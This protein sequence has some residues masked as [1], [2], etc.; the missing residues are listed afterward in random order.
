[1]K[2][3][4]KR[5][6]KSYME[7]L[8]GPV[9]ISAILLIL[10]L[11]FFLNNMA[12]LSTDLAAP[13][14]VTSAVAFTFAIPLLAMRSF[15][16]ETRNKTDQLYMT[17]PITIG[18]VVLGK[19]L[20][21]AALL[22]IPSGIACLLPLL[23]RFFSSE[24]QL[25]SCYTSLLAF[26]LYALMLTAICLFF[27]SLT[28]NVLLSAVFSALFIVVG[29]FMGSAFSRIKIVWLAKIL[30]NTLD[31][32]ARMETMTYNGTF[33]WTTV[34]YFV[35]VTAL[36]LF[37][38]VQVIQ[39][40]RYTVSRKNLTVGAYSVSMI[41]VMIAVVI[42]ANF[43]ATQIPERYRT[44]DVT[45]TR[46]RSITAES[47]KVIDKIEDPI[48]IYY[49]SEK[50]Q[51]NV[52]GSIDL[53]AQ[54]IENILKDFAAR[55]SNI[56]LQYVDPITN[57]QFYAKYSDKALNYFSV[58]V[59]DQ[60]TKRYKAID[61]NYMLQTQMN[62]QTYAQEVT[63]YDVEGKVINAIQTVSAPEKDLQKVYL[64]SGQDEGSLET[65]FQDRFAQFNMK[66]DPLDLT[67]VK[68]VPSDCAL[69]MIFAPIN[70]LSRDDADKVISYIQKG[71]NLFLVLSFNEQKEMPNLA[72]V[73]KL[74]GVRVEDGLAVEKDT[75]HLY[76][77]ARGS[78]NYYLYPE[79]G[80][81]DITASLKEGDGKIFVPASM[82]LS[83]DKKTKD[84]SYTELLTTS[85]DS[86]LSQDPK[87]AQDPQTG[88]IKEQ[89]GDRK[90]P[91]VL[92]LKAVSKKSTAVIFASD[93]MFTNAA[94]QQ[95]SGG[96]NL[97]L[98]GQVIRTF[99]SGKTD[100]VTIPVKQATSHLTVTLK[101]AMVTG[102]C[103]MAVVILI[104][105][106]GIMVFVSRRRK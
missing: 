60:K 73:L 79:I 56:T 46:I 76:N 50:D 30:S 28:D 94:D 39:K 95:V 88:S 85:K 51:S 78:V 22:A 14:Y 38:C 99:S 29:I 44:V 9:M 5:D 48:T 102:V 41:A 64:L 103:M 55:R 33:D 54:N 52:Y 24:V 61:V 7:N 66:T 83:Y 59:V 8:I 63:G 86:F 32:N 84:T 6:F 21:I 77:S 13:V 93:Q 92:G 71:G 65:D 75:S 11:F 10:F 37:L 31:F 105:V 17:A 45:G 87:E 49:L 20:A 18:Q 15:A 34:I 43:F 27:S 91:L 81:D 40:R 80:E 3:I 70:D 74:Y 47:R 72:S 25:R 106:Y 96:K 19:F 98:F 16:E 36:F 101:Q 67:S 4:W 104:L 23:M 97:K 90:G 12:G 100:F 26:Y 53:D 2:A 35:S 68:E 57:P 89:K 1:M 82:A 42:V 58:I 62:E 69:L